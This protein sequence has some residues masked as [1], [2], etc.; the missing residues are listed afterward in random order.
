M[1]GQSG[2]VYRKEL[3]INFAIFRPGNLKPVLDTRIYDRPRA[4]ASDSLMD[5]MDREGDRI[6]HD[7]KKK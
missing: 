4:N 3:E 5:S 7:L 1:G 6:K 2:P